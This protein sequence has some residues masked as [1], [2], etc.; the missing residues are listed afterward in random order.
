MQTE[1]TES[2]GTKFVEKTSSLIY[3]TVPA[4]V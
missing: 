4:A 2:S 1:I 3:K